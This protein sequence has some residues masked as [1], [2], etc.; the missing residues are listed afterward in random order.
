MTCAVVGD[1][2]GKTAASQRPRR[3]SQTQSQHEADGEGDQACNLA[4][5]ASAK[6]APGQKAKEGK[7]G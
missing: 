3:A 2:P 6:A 5:K 4:H 1:R 7:H